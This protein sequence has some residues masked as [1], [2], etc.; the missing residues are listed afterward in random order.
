MEDDSPRQ[1][2]VEGNCDGEKLLESTKF[3]QKKSY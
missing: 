2:K 3:Q 1:S